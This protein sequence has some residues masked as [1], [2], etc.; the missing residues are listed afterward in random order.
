MQIQTF[1]K[2][3]HTTF[4]H[5]D[6]VA[7]AELLGN[8]LVI[9][10]V[11]ETNLSSAFLAIC[12]MR[13][14]QVKAR[15]EHLHL[16]NTITL[17]V[18]WHWRKSPCPV[19]KCWRENSIKLLAQDILVNFLGC[20]LWVIL[21]SLPTKQET[22]STVALHVDG[23]QLTKGSRSAC[24]IIAAGMRFLP[25]KSRL[26]KEHSTSQRNPSSEWINHTFFLIPEEMFLVMS[27]FGHDSQTF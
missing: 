17:E 23:C 6:C 20:T 8:H 13:R 16:D 9:P 2:A 26:L 19:R 4:H 3:N 14:Q 24:P 10:L 27:L 5:T 18:W 15:Q 25:N 7:W 1:L 21:L 11:K 12:D 22:K